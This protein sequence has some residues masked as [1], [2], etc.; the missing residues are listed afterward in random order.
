MRIAFPPSRV[1]LLACALL[2][3][4]CGS[5]LRTRDP[6]APHP[7][8]HIQGAFWGSLGDMHA[9]VVRRLGDRGPAGLYPGLSLTTRHA[10]LTYAFPDSQLHAQ[11]GQGGESLCDFLVLDMLPLA[12]HPDTSY[13]RLPLAIQPLQELEFMRLSAKLHRDA[14][15][16]TQHFDV[17]PDPGE[18]LPLGQDSL[19]IPVLWDDV[20][21]SVI[22]RRSQ[23]LNH[24][25]L[26]ALKLHHLRSRLLS[27]LQAHWGH[28]YQFLL[29]G[30]MPDGSRAIVPCAP[31]TLFSNH[32]NQ[33]SPF[34]H[35]IKWRFSR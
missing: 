4:H 12:L 16:A 18:L 1:L 23:P 30:D 14:E 13:Y 31:L 28:R 34:E 21:T 25:E 20:D 32:P 3:L 29:P 35:G 27:G 19:L 15:G 5:R 9:H 2:G 11:T 7:H 22:I 17:F 33:R 6:D 26:A 24:L 10:T 8:A